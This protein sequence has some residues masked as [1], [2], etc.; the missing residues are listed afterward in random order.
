MLHNGYVCL[1]AVAY[2]CDDRV[3]ALFS[4]SNLMLH[5]SLLLKVERPVNVLF[6]SI[7]NLYCIHG[8]RPGISMVYKYETLLDL[9][10]GYPFIC[11]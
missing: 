3:S 8:L 2:A 11:S 6:R 9:V 10:Y 5:Y 7:S 4:K 1:L